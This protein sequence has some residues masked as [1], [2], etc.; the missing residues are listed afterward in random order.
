MKPHTA[1]LLAANL[2]VLV[3]GTLWAAEDK[4]PE[5]AK[6]RYA[7]V[8]S[9]PAKIK[10]D[11]SQKAKL[12]ELRK[13]YEKRLSEYDE[14][15]KRPG[16]DDTGSLAATRNKL[17]RVVGRKKNAILTDEQRRLLGLKDSVPPIVQ[18]KALSDPKVWDLSQLEK[19]FTIQSRSYDPIEGVISFMV[20]TKRKWTDQERS[21]DAMKWG[22]YYES[23]IQV[24][25]SNEDDESIFKL[26]GQC[27]LRTRTH[28]RFD[29][30]I[31][32]VP[33]KLTD[34]EA[35][36]GLLRFRIKIDLDRSDGLNGGRLTK[37]ATAKFVYPEPK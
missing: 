12:A 1:W 5:P 17:Y 15:V 19:L 3:S 37:A 8:F 34:K 6:D 30:G 18:A 13:E 20:I 23:P 9:F 16:L 21:I 27:I 26:A 28:P 14:Y 33:T 22:R 2:S 32:R 35:K 31:T 10:L 36:E 29:R 4:K 24:I 7:E 25:F 11:E